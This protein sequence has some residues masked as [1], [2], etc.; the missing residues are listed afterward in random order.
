VIP[1]GIDGD[2][3]ERR[4]STR[5][6][7][8]ST[9]SEKV[10]T[11]AGGPVRT[12]ARFDLLKYL[13]SFRLRLA[14]RSPLHRQCCCSVIRW[15]VNPRTYAAS[16]S[17]ALCLASC[18]FSA[19]FSLGGSPLFDETRSKEGVKETRCLRATRAP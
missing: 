6:G 2:V 5:P 1:D 3:E 11:A 8:N 7:N 13:R 9:K 17:V 10:R 18:S 16:A 12:F 14:A 19:L 15:F 4:L